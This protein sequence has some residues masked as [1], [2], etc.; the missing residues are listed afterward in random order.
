MQPG[1][2]KNCYSHQIWC[3][4]YISTM[5]K[6][7]GGSMYTLV[8]PVNSWACQIM[9]ESYK[10]PQDSSDSA[11]TSGK[12]TKEY[13]TVQKYESAIIDAL[14]ASPT[15][16]NSLVSKFIEKDWF[17]PKDRKNATAEVV[18]DGALT[19]IKLNSRCYREFIEML[20]DIPGM[21][22]ILEKLNGN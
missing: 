12:D 17:A 1:E 10:K 4:V 14:D 5:H 15:A 9:A 18:A 22:I 8:V 13:K 6:Y 3:A 11:T 19:R 21:D 16:V 2:K 20:R 7:V